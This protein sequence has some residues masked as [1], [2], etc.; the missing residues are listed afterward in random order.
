MS[1]LV[2]EGTMQ[3]QNRLLLTM[4]TFTMYGL[5]HYQIWSFA[6]LYLS[7]SNVN[8]LQFLNVLLYLYILL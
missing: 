2:V 5:F 6:S 1:H 7:K 8:M 3:P 4:Y